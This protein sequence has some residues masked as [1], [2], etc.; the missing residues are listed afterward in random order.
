MTESNLLSQF[1]E[2]CGEENVS[3]NELDRINYSSDLASL[4][5]V[6]KQMY[7]IQDPKYVLRPS[8]TEQLAEI[9][10]IARKYNLSFT[11][12]AGASS[13]T[14]A[15]IPVDDGLVLD[16]TRMQSI[17]DID[18]TSLQATV[19][20]GITWQKLNF[21]LKKLGFM[22][23]IH[24]SSSPSATV[25]GFISTGG[26][27]GIGA[28]KYGPINKQVQKLKVVLPSG[29]IREIVP[30][31]TSLFVGAEGT[32]GI[33]TEITLQIYPKSQSII[34]LA[35]G[36]ND[37]ESVIEAIETLIKSGITPYHTMLF[38]RKF[39]D[40]TKSLGLAGASNEIVLLLTLEGSELVVQG[41][42]DI[43]NNI[44][45][46][47]GQ[48]EKGFALEEWERRF[49][50]ELFIKRA[51]P[52]LIL[53]ELGVPL[54]LVPQLYKNLRLLGKSEGIELGF[55]GILGHGNTML[56]M[57]FILTDEQRPMDYFKV[58]LFSRKLTSVA[59]KLGGAPY[60]IG[61]WGSSYLPFVHSQDTLKIFSAI[62][63]DF[64]EKN[65]CNPGKITE[66][67]TPEQFRP[68]KP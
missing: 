37:L 31:M 27:A 2:I 45:P 19:Q 8:S 35:F 59:I 24:P 13:G 68:P 22:I 50:A 9:I 43:I 56:C 12:R 65:L 39:F 11:A 26:Y 48:L 3:D 52:S 62:K 30:P 58:L 64:D 40:V 16:M 15:V 41:A 42:L 4:P 67:R 1:I 38:D 25:G 28:P 23:G 33:V 55:C 32:L 14:G 46:V 44:F 10:K 21:R 66:D 53:L 17:L 63:Q 61:L 51:G 34:P 60:G 54:R 36:F 49:K 47:K 57:P 29:I 6:L 5:A 20:P 7:K 18:Q